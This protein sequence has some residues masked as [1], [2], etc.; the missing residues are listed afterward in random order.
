MLLLRHAARRV[1][2]QLSEGREEVEQGERPEGS[3]LL[4]P[5]FPAALQPIL[6]TPSA[7]AM[8]ASEVYEPG[9]LPASVSVSPDM[10]DDS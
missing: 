4:F 9:G 5:N 6:I 10:A 1:S 7:R 8:T 3:W 2:S